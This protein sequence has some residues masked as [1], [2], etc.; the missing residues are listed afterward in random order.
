VQCCSCNNAE[1]SILLSL[2]PHQHG[3]ADD[4]MT[5]RLHSSSVRCRAHRDLL[6]LGCIPLWRGAN[7]WRLSARL[8][9]S[10][11]EVTS[12]D[13]VSTAWCKGAVLSFRVPP[14]AAASARQEGEQG[15]SLTLAASEER[16]SPRRNEQPD[17]LR[18]TPLLLVVT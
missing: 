10:P 5:D 9:R 1:C 17:T 3:W 12:F 7:Q 13:D 6:L 18:W 2:G 15:Q 4:L 16:L 14:V 11:D 8:Y